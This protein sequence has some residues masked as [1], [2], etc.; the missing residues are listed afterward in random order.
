MIISVRNSTSFIPRETFVG[1]LLR[2]NW[3]GTLAT[4]Y[5]KVEQFQRLQMLCFVYHHAL[6][7]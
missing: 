3:N 4:H 5:I 7:Q 6:L 2:T 1:L